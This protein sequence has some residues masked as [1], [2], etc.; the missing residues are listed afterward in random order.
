MGW[1]RTKNY[2]YLGEGVRVDNLLV[3]TKWATV[4][5]GGLL[6]GLLGGWDLALQVL[7]LFAVLDYI[8]GVAAAY[9]EK[10]LDSNVGGRGILRKVLIFVVVAIAYW[11]DLLIGQQILRSVVIFYYIANEGLSVVENLG[12]AGV[13]IPQT[14]KTA[15]EALKQ[16]S[17]QA[18]PGEHP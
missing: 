15:L 18:P 4:L 12:R 17:E 6:V 16:K 13:P 7:V 9:T 8:T 5:V 2:N 3:Y 11:L 1:K 10:M 14:L